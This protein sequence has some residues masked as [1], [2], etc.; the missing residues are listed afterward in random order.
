MADFAKTGKV[1]AVCDTGE[2][3][4]WSLAVDGKTGTLY[5]GTG[6][7]GRVYRISAEG[8]AEVLYTAKQEHVLCVATVEA[9]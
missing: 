6:P 1:K 8:K 2:P 9:L 5:A 4:V 7:H 3:Y